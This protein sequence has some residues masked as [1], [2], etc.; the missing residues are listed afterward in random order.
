MS[1]PLVVNTT[2]GTCWT[3]RAVTRGG[4]P[5]YAP[6][7]VCSCPEFV[8]VTEAELAEHGIVGSADVLPVPVG[9]ASDSVAGET[10]AALTDTLD[11]HLAGQRELEQLQARVAELEAERH[12]TNEVLSDAMVAAS[13]DKLTRLLAPTQA[14]REDEPVAKQPPIVYHAEHPDSGIVLGTYSNREAAV[15]HCEALA[16]R[17][18]ATGLVSW[19]PDDGDAFSP[20]ELTYFDVEYCDGDDVPVQTCTGYVVTPLEIA[21]AYDEEAD[22]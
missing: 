21:S 15:A 4:L 14:L 17:E 7:G 5:L 22:E 11:A 3:R 8:M 1:A 10:V 16:T 12:S 9:A 18:G 2:D 20:E 13:A 6:E 19:V